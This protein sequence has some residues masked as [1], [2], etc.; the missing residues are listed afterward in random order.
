MTVTKESPHNLHPHR[1][2]D[3]VDEIESLLEI[4]LRQSELIFRDLFVVEN[5]SDFGSRREIGSTN[6]MMESPFEEDTGQEE[7]EIPVSEILF[8]IP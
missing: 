3:P 7:S 4:L 8:P 6:V 2:V 5:L 1:H